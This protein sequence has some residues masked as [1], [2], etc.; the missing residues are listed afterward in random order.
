MFKYNVESI[1]A[2]FAS[3]GLKAHCRGCD[4]LVVMLKSKT[5][6]W[7]LNNYQMLLDHPFFS[8]IKGIRSL[9]SSRISLYSEI[10]GP[11]LIFS[12]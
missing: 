11:C 12:S 1:Q 9:S 4:W 5:K 7:S 6:L 3:F 10:T 8:R 2:K